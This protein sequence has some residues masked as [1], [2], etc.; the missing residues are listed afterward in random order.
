MRLCAR[1]H[2]TVSRSFQE[3]S[4]YLFIGQALQSSLALSVK[5]RNLL[6][7]LCSSL[8]SSLALLPMSSP[9][10]VCHFREDDRCTSELGRSLSRSNDCLL[11]LSQTT[12]NRLSHATIAVRCTSFLLRF[13]RALNSSST[14]PL[15]HF[16]ACLLVLLLKSGTSYLT[17]LLYRSSEQFLY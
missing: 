11:G 5:H 10:A 3:L 17:L 4:D 9:K 16:V 8:H 6:P 1:S 2:C 14:G 13:Q 7:I 15:L 12:C